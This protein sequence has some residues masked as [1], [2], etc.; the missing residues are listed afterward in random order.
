MSTEIGDERSWT[1]AN[2]LLG[3]SYWLQ[4]KPHEAILYLGKGKE[5]AEELGD[6]DILNYAALYIGLYYYALGYLNKAAGY[7]K[8][9]VTQFAWTDE[10]YI[11][12]YEVPVLLSYCDINRCD[13]NRPVGTIDFFRQFAIK[14]QDYYTASLYR[15]IL[16]ITLWVIGKREEAIFHLEGTQSDSLAVRNMVAHWTSLHGL[17]SLYFNEGDID[18]GLPLSEKILNMN[19][20]AGVVHFIFHPIFLE[21]YFNAEQA[22]CELPA[23][24]HFDAVFERIM[25]DPNIDLQGNCPET[26]CRKI[27]SC[28]KK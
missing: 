9:F 10:E 21:S 19:N 7:L 24:W 26:S 3:R 8:P 22:G 20:L 17:A 27:H 14:R 28:R 2:M 18:K 1:M 4:S 5:K 16:G 13:F 23:E 15:A 11:L 25:A 12:G 6:H